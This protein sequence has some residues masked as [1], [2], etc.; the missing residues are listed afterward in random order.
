MGAGDQFGFAVALSGEG[1]ALLVG[2]PLED[3]S[4]TGAGSVPNEGALDSGAAYFFTTAAAI[5]LWTERAFIK[6]S[7]TGVQDAF[8][9]AVAISAA[10]PYLIA[11]G[12]PFENSSGVGIGTVP[13]ESA[14]DSGAAYTYAFAGASVTFE[15]FI[16]ALNSGAGDNFGSSLE[17]SGDARTLV[18]GAVHEDSSG[19]N[20]GSV[21]NEAALESGAVYAYLR[22]AGAWSGTAFIKASNT[23][24]DDFFG[25]QLALDQTGT[26]LA[27]GATFEDGSGTG[28]GLAPNNAGRD[29]GAVYIFR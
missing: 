29:T 9:S 22:P 1:Q 16:K 6:A 10:S 18:V 15:S 4:G 19:T 24:A 20:V 23:G 14:P 8:G 11:V 13:N 7:N 2:A 3:S 26:T 25:G 21:P 28:V 27:I 5:G 17:V 12:A